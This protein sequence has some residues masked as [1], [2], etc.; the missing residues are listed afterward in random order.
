MVHIAES[1]VGRWYAGWFMSGGGMSFVEWDCESEMGVESWD[2]E[3]GDS[4]RSIS[5]ERGRWTSQVGEAG[6]CCV[7]AMGESEREEWGRDSEADSG[8][9]VQTVCEEEW[10]MMD[11]R[12]A[13]AL[14]PRFL[15]SFERTDFLSFEMTGASWRTRTGGVVVVCLCAWGLVERQRRVEPATRARAE[16]ERRRRRGSGL[17]VSVMEEV[18]SDCLG[19]H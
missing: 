11:L 6:S 4:E 7:Q 15:R 1:T 8:S 14:V 17:S 18:R 3:R 16:R 10:S 9:M 5:L 13:L 12:R 19:R 2:S